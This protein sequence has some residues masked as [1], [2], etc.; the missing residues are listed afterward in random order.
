MDMRNQEQRWIK[1][2]KKSGNEEA[3]NALIEKYYREMFAFVYKQ[4]VD[5]ELSLDL[6]Q[7]IFISVL[8]SIANFDYKKASFRTWLYRV[9]SNRVVDYF[10]SK[11]Y[12]LAKYSDPLEDYEFTEPQDIA[13]SLE[14]KEDVKQ[15]ISI[16]SRMGTSTQ[17]IVRLKL[18][19]EYTLNEIA[20][21]VQAPLSTVKTRYYTAVKIIKK[22]MR[23]HGYE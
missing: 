7:E 15:V 16:I 14:Y 5:Y 22:E 11:H 4:T 19:G 8:R 2:I 3:A 21:M 17:Q 13:I 12:Q 6:T 10:R 1:K 9:A 18:F 20:D 23:E